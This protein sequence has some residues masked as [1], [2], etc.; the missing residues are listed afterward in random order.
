[1]TPEQANA[2][3]SRLVWSDPIGQ[4]LS[5]TQRSAIILAI[6]HLKAKDLPPLKHPTA[7]NDK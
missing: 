1:M 4:Q 2:V 3:L 5:Q 7:H 6:A